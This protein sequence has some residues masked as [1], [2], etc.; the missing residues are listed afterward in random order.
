MR[1]GI[2]WVAPLLLLVF[3][4]ACESGP[5]GP[6]TLSVEVTAPVQLGAAQV[7]VQGPGITAIRGLG[8]SEVA[9]RLVP[10]SD[11]DD[12]YRVVAFAPE[13]GPIR[14][15]VEVESTDATLQVV[16]LDAAGLDGIRVGVAGVEVEV[17]R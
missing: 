11:A 3:A 6:G 10:T 7:R 4:A 8:G 16:A 2:R 15:G 12:A 1:A 9:S 13:G 17:Q 14:I 5:A